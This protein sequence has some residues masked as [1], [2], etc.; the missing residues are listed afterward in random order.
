MNLLSLGA[1]VVAFVLGSCGFAFLLG[2]AMHRSNV[3]GLLAEL[4][5]WREQKSQADNRDHVALCDRRI[6][7]CESFLREMG[8]LDRPKKFP[9]SELAPDAKSSEAT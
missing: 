8:Y 3:Q 5:Y 7:E 1:L 9:R 2:R 6:L 4:R